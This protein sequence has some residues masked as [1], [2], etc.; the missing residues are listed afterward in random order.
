MAGNL[1]VWE[2]G[3]YENLNFDKATRTYSGTPVS[4][5]PVRH[6]A[7]PGSLYVRFGGD[8]GSYWVMTE[9]ETPDPNYRATF[10]PFY[11]VVRPDGDVH[12][13]IDLALPHPPPGHYKLT[14]S[15]A[16]HWLADLEFDVESGP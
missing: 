1:F 4:T 10:E 14:V 3:L 12:H 13:V 6:G 7:I 9:L 15:V 16:G 5:V 11:A 8:P 2:M